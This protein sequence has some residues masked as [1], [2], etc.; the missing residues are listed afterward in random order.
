MYKNVI[1]KTLKNILA[2]KFLQDLTVN[3]VVNS[4]FEREI[5]DTILNLPSIV[6]QTHARVH[7]I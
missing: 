4:E 6:L 1:K 5:S 7:D 2:N 3:V